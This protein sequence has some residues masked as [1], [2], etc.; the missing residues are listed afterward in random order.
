[1]KSSHNNRSIKLFFSF[2][3]SF[4]K[5]RDQFEEERIEKKEKSGAAEV[6][7]QMGAL[8]AALPMAGHQGSL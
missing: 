8:T 2:F 5:S 3:L 6:S 7:S 1:M 4:L